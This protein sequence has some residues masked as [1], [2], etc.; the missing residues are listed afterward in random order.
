MDAIIEKTKASALEYMQKNP[1][2]WET[3]KRRNR[4]IPFVRDM[5]PDV[6]DLMKEIDA[7]SGCIHSSASI[8]I[9]MRSLE[10]MC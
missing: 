1:Q 5:S 9:I 3:L 8:A 6:L 7:Y 2:S 10:S 4:S